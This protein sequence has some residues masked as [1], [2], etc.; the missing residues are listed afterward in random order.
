MDMPHSLLFHAFREDHAG[1]GRGLYELDQAVRG[2]RL[3]E[4]KA[5]AQKLDREAGPHIAFE[6]RYFYPALKAL[7]GEDEVAR[8]YD[9][10][11]EGLAAIRFVAAMP[12]KAVLNASQR[13]DLLRKLQLMETHVAECGTLFGTMGRMPADQQAR[14]Y[15]E[16]L[17]LREQ[18]PRWTQFGVSERR[19]GT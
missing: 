8:L 18:G 15:S 10:H 5:I 11:A 17:A 14:L 12:A 9:E 4:A 6:E 7:I 1:L 16:L 19:T 3:K 2:E 13:Q